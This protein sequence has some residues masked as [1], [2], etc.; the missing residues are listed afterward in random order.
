MPAD[1]EYD[2]VDADPIPDDLPGEPDPAP[3]D[4]PQ[5]G[6]PQ[7]APESG[8]EPG[9]EPPPEQ[10]PQEPENP[11]LEYYRSV[12]GLD[13][14]Q[15]YADDRQ[16]LHG[17]A[18]AYRLIGRPDPDK[19]LGR[20]FREHGDDFRQYL[21][22]RGQ[23]KTEPEPEKP[24]TWEE[25]QRWRAEIIDPTTGRP[26]EDADPATVRRYREATERA[27][28]AIFELANNPQQVLEPFLQQQ[29]QQVQQT[30]Q[31]VAQQQAALQRD[32][33]MLQGWAEQNKQV[34]FNNGDPRQGLTP[35]GV[36]I[37]QLHDHAAQMGVQS[38]GH[39]L[40]YATRLWQA[41]QAQHTQNSRQPSPHAQRQPGVA[42][43]SAPQPSHAEK[44]RDM[45]FVERCIY[46]A[47]QREAASGQMG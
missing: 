40:D 20:F 26:R 30:A 37:C 1:L 35:H 28:R 25:V 47:K 17:L 15:K 23:Q 4:L 5:E 36:R 31:Q 9:G 29:Q 33:A 12:E 2:N 27:Q 13:L 21:E 7:P 42:A 24:P 39:R 8:G 34:L 11:I 10:P 19:E 18:E 3:S 38:I 6:Q 46:E 16:A 32:Q 44:V 22:R 45:D 41:E 14:G 43:P